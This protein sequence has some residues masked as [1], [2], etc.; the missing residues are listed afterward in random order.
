MNKRLAFFLV[1]LLVLSIFIFYCK[2]TQDDGDG[3]DGG[4]DDLYQLS[5][6][7]QPD[8]TYG[9]ITLDPEPIEDNSY[10]SGEEVTLTP[11]PTDTN[12]TFVRWD[13]DIQSI[14]KDITVT[15]NNDINL[16]AIFSDDVVPPAPVQDLTGTAGNEMVNLEWFDPS[17]TDLSHIHVYWTPGNEETPYQV[18][19]GLEEV[20]LNGLSNDTEYTFTVKA[21]D[22]SFNESSGE[23][24]SLTPSLPDPPTT[25][26]NVTASPGYNL[27]IKVTWD[28][29]PTAE[30]YTI[31]WA[32]GDTIP[33][34]YNDYEEETGI[35][36]TEIIFQPQDGD[37]NPDWSYLGT[38]FTFHVKAVNAGGESDFSDMTSAYLGYVI[39]IAVAE[40]DTAT[41]VIDPEQ[42]SYY[43]NETVNIE[44]YEGTNGGVWSGWSGI[45]HGNLT[46]LGGGVYSVVMDESI[47]LTANFPIPQEL[48]VDEGVFIDSTITYDTDST[49][50]WF[51]TGLEG[52]EYRIY[53]DDDSF[54][55]GSGNYTGDVKVSAYEE[56][57]LTPFFE[58]MDYGYGVEQTVI[59]PTGQ[60][61]VNLFVEPLSY[62]WNGDSWGDYGIQILDVSN[63]DM[64]LK[65]PDNDDL[66]NG[67]T[68]YPSSSV[69]ATN[70]VT[71][72]YTFTI[73][74]TGTASLEL[75]GSPL[76]D[77][78][79]NTQGVF[80]ITQQ[81]GS[82]IPIGGSETFQVTYTGNA[83]EGIRNAT[84]QIDTNDTENDPYIFSVEVQAEMPYSEIDVQDSN[85][86]TIPDS[87]SFDGGSVDGSNG[88]ITDYDFTI[89]NTGVD[90]I[91]NITSPISISGT[92][93]SMFNVETDPTSS[94]NPGES[95]TFT[96]RF[97]GD[98][99][100]YG[101]RT[102]TIEIP[103]DETGIS[104]GIGDGIDERPYDFTIN[105]DSLNVL[106]ADD[107]ETGDFTAQS[108][109]ISGDYNPHVVTNQT[110]NVDWDPSGTFDLVAQSGTNMVQFGV[111]ETDD[112]AADT[113]PIGNGERSTLEI[114]V[115]VS[116]GDTIS[117]WY[118]VSCEDS[119]ESYLR[120]F[121]NGM[122]EMSKKYGDIDWTMFTYTFSADDTYTLKW[123]YY[124]ESSFPPASAIHADCAWIDNVIIGN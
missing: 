32:E 18:A 52:H 109:V 53:W 28:E 50:R 14:D 30:S 1:L 37:G 7:I 27:T 46:D 61:L 75:E 49:D 113:E 99:S 63:P 56:D 87:S 69:D 77:I 120:F 45:D 48:T 29:V 70:G 82:S 16:I 12:Y 39:R 86:V 55:G 124:K 31:Q 108:W 118:K 33:D 26:Q 59:I 65:D 64:L 105:V 40:D 20:T 106:L 54:A 51:F 85:S 38:Q 47:T 115:T 2:P 79:Q 60:T 42:P 88:V 84:F 71:T 23:T 66:S 41:I 80:S 74:N 57:G 13:G 110:Y 3:G 34:P 78:T 112:T 6:T 107:F 116:A 93:A 97:T 103:N 101:N 17:D 62:Q 22:T 83:S 81:P 117:F 76:V 36:D 89:E 96:V 15:M 24:I 94:I 119:P 44:V 92:D 102:A 122:W 90:T 68:Y 123:E 98:G 114:V 58:T 91:L 19:A 10:H 35:T 11:N 8:D 4:N 43:N 5:I 104:S 67:S 72:D 111:V 121:V 9:S 95:T 73:Q 21:V 100:S 25:P